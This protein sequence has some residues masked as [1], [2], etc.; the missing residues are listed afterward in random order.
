MPEAGQ[1]EEGAGIAKSGL[2]KRRHELE[3]AEAAGGHD[4]EPAQKRAKQ[5][6]TT[7][8][9]TSSAASGGAGTGLPWVDLTE[10]DESPTAA[11]VSQPAGA[12][13]AVELLSSG[14]DDDTPLSDVGARERGGRRRELS[15]MA[16]RPEEA[17]ASRAVRA[18]GTRRHRGRNVLRNRLDGRARSAAT[19][20]DASAAA[21]SGQPD[22]D[23]DARLARQL[24]Q[25]EDEQA[26]RMYRQRH[27]QQ[28]QVERERL[29][30]ELEDLRDE[31]EHYQQRQGFVESWAARMAGVAAQ[32]GLGDIRNVFQSPDEPWRPA[33][34]NAPQGGGR[35]GRG[36]AAASL[37]HRELTEADYDELSQL[38]QGSAGASK[39]LIN[40]LIKTKLKN[41][42]ADDCCICMDQMKQNALVRILPCTHTFHARCADK[43]LKQKNSCPMCQRPI[44]ASE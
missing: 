11:S 38:D 2:S 42:H 7:K 3:A 33:G 28:W 22:I 26:T 36:A 9:G 24:Q 17:C 27:R 43:W 12:R 15:W 30:A 8:S 21:A 25:Q 39:E 44:D 32:L 19:G 5:A 40:S 23:A 35:R 13:A 10:D 1:Q 37:Q 18:D 14:S 4:G 6:D 20:A 31:E 34:H 41:D 29:R 16:P